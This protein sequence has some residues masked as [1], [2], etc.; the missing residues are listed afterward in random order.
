MVGILSQAFSGILGFAFSKAEGSGVGP[1]WLGRLDVKTGLHA[2]GLSG[3]RWMYVRS[4][5]GCGPLNWRRSSFILQGIVTVFIALVAYVTIVNFPETA[6]RTFGLK[7]LNDA[8]SKWIVARLQADR[9]DVYA[10]K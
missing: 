6:H 10:E 4:F 1:A 3:W 7:F 2:P 9:E 5:L 8:E